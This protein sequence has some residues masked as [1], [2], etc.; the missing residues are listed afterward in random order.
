MESGIIYVATGDR[1]RDEAVGACTSLKQCMPHV[2]V[3]LFTDIP[4]VA[5]LFDHVIVL[6]NPTCD[7]GDKIRGIQCSPFVRTIF[8]DTDTCVCDDI[9]DLFDLLDHFDL[10]V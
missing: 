3:A 1:Y 6:D 5:S 8:L 4:E 7:F 10:A 9:S 2:P